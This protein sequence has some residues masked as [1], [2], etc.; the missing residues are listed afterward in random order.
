MTK[1]WQKWRLR[2]HLVDVIFLNVD[3][4]HVQ[5][6]AKISV[7]NNHDT[8]WSIITPCLSTYPPHGHRYAGIVW[9]IYE[10]RHQKTKKNKLWIHGREWQNSECTWKS[11]NA[12]LGHS[13]HRIKNEKLKPCFTLYIDRVPYFYY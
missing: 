11:L 5:T 8:S 13:P 3:H 4:D 1:W 7:G 12:K 10:S 6:L 2:W 9:N